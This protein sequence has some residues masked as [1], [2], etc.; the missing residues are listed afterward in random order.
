ME[1]VLYLKS[2]PQPALCHAHFPDFLGVSV[3]LFSKL[4]KRKKSGAEPGERDGHLPQCAQLKALP[5]SE[6]RQT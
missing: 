4:L 1:L 6:A 3:L 5:R 2:R